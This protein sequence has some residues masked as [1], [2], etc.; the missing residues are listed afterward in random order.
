MTAFPEESLSLHLK[1][2]LHSEEPLDGIDWSQ[3][4]GA[5]YEVE[6]KRTM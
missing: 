5:V 1:R 4:M 3:L 2:K 6:T